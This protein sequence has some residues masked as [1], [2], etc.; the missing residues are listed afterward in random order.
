LG[1]RVRRHARRSWWRPVRRAGFPEEQQPWLV[2]PEPATL[3]YGIPV[4]PVQPIH[5]DNTKWLLNK[6]SEDRQ[7]AFDFIQEQGLGHEFLIWRAQR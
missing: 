2:R 4:I 6:M 5:D 1:R 7:L 3:S